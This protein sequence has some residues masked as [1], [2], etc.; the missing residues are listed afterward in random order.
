MVVKLPTSVAIKIQPPSLKLCPPFSG[1]WGGGEFQHNT[2]GG[3]LETDILAK[4][5]D[6]GFYMHLQSHVKGSNCFPSQFNQFLSHPYS[7]GAI[8]SINE[9]WWLVRVQSNQTA[10]S[11]AVT[12]L[13]K[14][15]M[16]EIK[17]LP[18]TDFHLPVLWM[19]RCFP[20]FIVFQVTDIALIKRKRE[21]LI[22]IYWL[23]LHHDSQATS[24][25]KR[26]SPHSLV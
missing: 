11:L 2:S 22:L 19:L 13:T 4:K 10:G 5:V 16:R 7:V 18:I 9:C 24:I 6:A 25:W 23:V 17:R 21:K 8:G 3:D 14:S 15:L 1:W 12:F 26:D 20:D